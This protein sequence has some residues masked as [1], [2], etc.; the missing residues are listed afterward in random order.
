MGT[1]TTQIW[2]WALDLYEAVELVK[3]QG[4]QHSSKDLS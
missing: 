1:C 2:A 3:N 4:S